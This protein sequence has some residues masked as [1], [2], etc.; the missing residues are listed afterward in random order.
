MGNDAVH[1]VCWLLGD[2][3]NGDMNKWKV[4]DGSYDAKSKALVAEKSFGGKAVLNDSN[5]GDFTYEA[6]VVIPTVQPG[7]SNVGLVFRVSNPGNGADSYRG[8]YAGIGTDGFIVLGRANQDWNQLSN[9]QA[10][11]TAGTSYH[12]MVRAEGDALEVYLDDMSKPKISIRD[13][14]YKTGMAGI[15]VF[16]TGAVFDNIKITY[17]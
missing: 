13:A 3:R 9:V 10:T 17:L 1:L 12:L 4:Y 6:D 11:I 15:R 16:Q 14:T 2:F 5:F 8:Y 7:S